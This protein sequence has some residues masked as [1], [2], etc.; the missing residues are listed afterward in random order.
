MTDADLDYSPPAGQQISITK[1]FGHSPTIR[2]TLSPER[3][4]GRC[5]CGWEGKKHARSYDATQEAT[6][7]YEAEI[8][9]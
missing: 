2:T 6:K 9:V 3:H 5:T 8:F 7:H 1:M 4:Q